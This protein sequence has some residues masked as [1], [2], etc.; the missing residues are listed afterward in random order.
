MLKLNLNM[1]SLHESLAK[2]N[3]AILVHGG[4]INDIMNQLQL[5]TSDRAMGNVFERMSTSVHRELGE[6][7]AKFKLDD[8]NFVTEDHGTADAQFFK[9]QVDLF[10]DKLDIISQAILK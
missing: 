2:I 10:T 6:K 3:D 1:D 5:K 4:Q 7:Q 8:P 9:S